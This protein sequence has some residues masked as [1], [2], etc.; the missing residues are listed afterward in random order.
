[1]VNAAIKLE[2]PEWYMINMSSGNRKGG[3]PVNT[4]FRIALLRSLLKAGLITREEYE[5]LAA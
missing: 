2:K 4:V 5:K 3:Y 1:M